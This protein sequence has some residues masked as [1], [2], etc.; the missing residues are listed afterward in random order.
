MM[1]ENVLSPVRFEEDSIS[2]ILNKIILQSE[3]RGQNI[4]DQKST[5]MKAITSLIHSYNEIQDSSM[6]E[7]EFSSL[8]K[9]IK[10]EIFPLLPQQV[11]EKISPIIEQF[12]FENQSSVWEF[13][14]VLANDVFY[15]N[16]A[17]QIQVISEGKSNQE[18]P[19]SVQQQLLAQI[20]EYMNSIGLT[21]E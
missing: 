15:T 16:I 4:I 14:Q 11:V 3:D 18:H 21:M 5:I 19:V 17:N 7:E 1:T 6:N 2:F 10:Q 13:L 8:V 12:T 9:S 20:T